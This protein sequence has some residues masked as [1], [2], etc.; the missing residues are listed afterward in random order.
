VHHCGCVK[1]CMEMLDVTPCVTE[2]LMKVI[3]K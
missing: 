1:H 3:N 2:T